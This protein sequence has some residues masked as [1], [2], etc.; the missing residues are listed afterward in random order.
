MNFVDISY[1]TTLPLIGNAP[2][3]V[4]NSDSN[5]KFLVKFFDIAN[6]KQLI[7]EVWCNGGE[8]VYGDR[9]WFTNWLIEIYDSNNQLYFYDK[10]DLTGKTVFIKMDGHA[11]GDNLAWIQYVE[12]FR[13]KW[14]CNVIC[15]TFWNKLFIK[16][17]P[18]ILFVEPNT[19]IHNIYAQYYVGAHKSSGAYSQFNVDE[20]PLQVAASSILGL[21]Q[22]ERRPFI[23]KFLENSKPRIS[24]RY[25]CLSEHASHEKKMWREPGGWQGIVDYLNS[26]GIA[27]VV[28]SKEPT[29]L[30][31]VIN[32]TGDAPIE[33]RMLDIYHS[34]CYLGVSSGLSWLAWAIGS[35]VI[36]ISDGTP[37]WH[38]FNEDCKRFSEND[39]QSVDYEYTN[40]TPLKKVITYLEEWL[41][42]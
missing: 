34:E 20:I 33:D 25:V 9:Q 13:I 30:N 2:R 5:Q 38:E 39:L 3:V 29:T 40:I 12:D 42:F 7:K 41:V 11:L 16:S 28:V 35:K 27:V 8:P 14:S 37:K 1:V 15:S 23:G 10:F 6:G 24:G 18:N 21:E 4:I 26:V 22:K 36:M 19:T 31:N 17:Y 32:L